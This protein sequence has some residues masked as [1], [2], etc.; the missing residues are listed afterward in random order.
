M[1]VVA[2]SLGLTSRELQRNIVSFSLGSAATVGICTILGY[3][4]LWFGPELRM[5][6]REF[7]DAPA[8]ELLDKLDA[9]PNFSLYRAVESNRNFLQTGPHPDSTPDRRVRRVLYFSRKE[10][11]V[12]GVVHFGADVEGPP[13][14]VHGGCTAAVLDAVAGVA[15][16]RTNRMPCVTAN[17]N[18][19]Y[20]EKIPLGSQL[21]VECKHESSDGLR[22]SRFS[23][24]LFSLRDPEKVYAN[25]D[26]LFIN[27][28]IPSNKKGLPPF[29]ALK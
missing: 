3:L 15:A 12:L 21:G 29:L 13:R 23:F 6:N 19:N 11:T 8:C 28:V 4:P 9:D 2:H 5:W 22:K 14:S 17:L 18:V 16:Y 26:A 10:R 27:A 25:G 20:R 7:W 24:K 1:D